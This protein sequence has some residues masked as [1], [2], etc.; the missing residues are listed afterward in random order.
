MNELET[1]LDEVSHDKYGST[2][3][4]EILKSD[5]FKEDFENMIKLIEEHTKQKGRDLDDG[6]QM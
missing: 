6:F 4:D 1:L 3:I 5:T 2:E